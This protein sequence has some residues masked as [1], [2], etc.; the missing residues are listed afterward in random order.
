M[1]SLRLHAEFCLLSLCHVQGSA[2]AALHHSRESCDLPWADTPS[3]HAALWSTRPVPGALM[4]THGSSPSSGPGAGVR[5][6][7]MRLSGRAV[8]RSHFGWRVQGQVCRCPLQ[9]LSVPEGPWAGSSLLRLSSANTLCFLALTYRAALSLTHTTPHPAT[10]ISAELSHLLQP[11]APADSHPWTGVQVPRWTRPGFHPQKQWC[12][13]CMH[14]VDRQ[15]PGARTVVQP[16]AASRA[17]SQRRPWPATSNSFGDGTRRHLRLWVGPL[18][19]MPPSWEARSLPH[20]S[21]PPLPSLFPVAVRL[22][23]GKNFIYE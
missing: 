16:G 6:A 22:S 11:Q 17:C 2:P 19:W 13:L 5:P 10:P 4:E 20:P 3:F 1:G 15:A 9:A 18:R 8:A 7:H 23:L 21:L 14:E 12:P